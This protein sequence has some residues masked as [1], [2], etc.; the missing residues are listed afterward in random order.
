MVPKHL[1]KSVSKFSSYVKTVI[2]CGHIFCVHISKPK[3]TTGHNDHMCH[4]PHDPRCGFITK[5]DQRG[6]RGV[7]RR[8]KVVG[9]DNWAPDPVISGGTWGPYKWPKNTWIT[10][11]ITLLIRVIPSL[12]HFRTWKW[13]VG[14]WSFPL[15]VSAYFQGRNVILLPEYEPK[16]PWFQGPGLKKKGDIV[17]SGEHISFQ[18]NKYVDL[19]F[20]QYHQRRRLQGLTGWLSWTCM[21]FDL[22]FKVKCPKLTTFQW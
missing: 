15:G 12:K 7:P 16:S 6:H 20:Q 18:G 3:K 11:V 1:P 17:F 4:L 2:C 21:F 10:R 19:Q 13:M 14:R 8:E 9:W 5:N 22:T